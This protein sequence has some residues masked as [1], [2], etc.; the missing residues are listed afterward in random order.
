MG[1]LLRKVND[2][3]RIQRPADSHWLSADDAPAA[4]VREFAPS[5]STQSDLSVWWI[6]DEGEYLDD[7]LVAIAAG[8]SQK[9]KLPYLVFPE[10]PIRNAFP[11]IESEGD[12][13]HASASHLHR[14]IAELTARKV[15]ELTAIACSQ[16]VREHELEPMEVLDLLEKAVRAGRLS[17]S[18]LNQR[19]KL[20]AEIR[21]RLDRS[22]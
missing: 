5:K 22:T 9:G 12:T 4:A 15:G 19:S 17:I 6:G 1:L 11:L 10:E 21:D 7:V 13:P 18:E 8:W 14:D 2:I 3:D 16:K 20:V